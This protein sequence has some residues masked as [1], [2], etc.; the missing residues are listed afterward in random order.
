MGSASAALASSLDYE[1]T[2]TTVAQ[3]AVP[4]L[5]D[6][7]LV[8]VATEDGRLRRVAV[9]HVDPAKVSLA[10]EL[11][12]RY[13]EKTDLEAGVYH[14]FRTGKSEL[15]PEITEEL[16]RAAAHDEGHLSLLRQLG[17]TSYLCVPLR[18]TGKTVGVITL[19]SASPERRYTERDRALAEDL[20]AR[21]ALA[22]ENARLY[23]E[24]QQSAEWLSTTLRSIGDAVV[25]TDQTGAVKFLNPVAEHLTGW[26]LA[27]AAGQPL[28]EVFKIVNESTGAPVE[29]PVEKALATGRIV[30]LANHTEL[31]TRSGSRIAIDDSAAPIFDLQGQITGVVLVFRDVT[32]QRQTERD[33]AERARLATF[34]A[35]IHMALSEAESMDAMLKRCTDLTVEFLDAAFVRIW[36]LDSDANVLE[37]HA[38][39]GLY[40]HLNG[41]HGRIPVGSFKIG[42]IA[43]EKRPHLTNHVIGDPRVPN[44]EWAQKEKLVSFAG[45]PLMIDGSVIGV[46][47]MFARHELSNATL[48]VLQTVSQSVALGIQ[49]KQAELRLRE[50]GEWFSVTLGSI[51]DAVMTVDM[52]GCI[53][54]LNAVAEAL[55]GW[56]TA[57]ACGRSMREVLRLI[58]ESTREPAVNPIDRALDEGVVVGLA[59]H[60]T[61]IRR[62]GREM[63][64]EDSAAPIRDPHGKIIGAVMVFHDVSERRQKELELERS[65][66]RFRLMSEVVPQLLYATTADGTVEYLNEAWFT[67]TGLSPD[68]LSWPDIAH[69]EDKDRTFKVWKTALETGTLYETECRIRRRDGEYRWFVSRAVPLRDDAGQIVRW[70]GSCTDI[71]EQKLTEEAL[72]EEY[73]ITEYLQEVAKALATE[74][75]LSKVVQIITDAGTRITRAQFGAFF[76][77]LLDEKGASYMLYTLSGVPRAAFD[78]FP[79]PRATHLFGPTFRGEGVI[80]AD[81]IRKDPRFG[82]NAPHYGMPAGHLPVVSYLA[83]P[84]ISRSGEVLGGL[85][86]GH[87]EAGVFTERDEKIIVGVAA[88]AAAAMDAARL[89]QREQ[90]ARALAEQASQAKDHFLATLSHELRTPLTPVLA[91]LSS[92]QQDSAL[93]GTIAEDLETVRRN[94]EL[95]ARLIDDLLDLT[96]ITRGKLE[97]HCHHVPIGRVIE[98]AIN[99]CLPDLKAK[100]LTL[101][102]ELRG[103][104]EIIFADSARITQILWNLLKNAIKFTPS[105]GTITVRSKVVRESE[106]EHVIVEVQDTGMGIDPSR[107]GSV[108]EAFEQGDRKITKQFGGLGLGLAISKAIAQSHSGTLAVASKGMGHGSTFTLTLPL[109]GCV[110]GDGKQ[111]TPARS[112]AEAVPTATI[113]EEASHR[114]LRILLVEDHA[115]TAAILSRVLRRMGHDVIHAGTVSAALHSA[116][117]E[118]QGEGID[119]VMSDLGLPDG[120]GLDLMRELSSK[121]SLR[122]IALSGFGMESDLEQSSAAGFSRHLIKPIDISVVRTTIAELMQTP[123]N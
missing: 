95:E 8:D 1:Q 46:I 80:R 113:N 110:D 30:G 66:E 91:I 15:V 10:R 40:T 26:P 117:A 92:L 52:N 65:E 93:P 100:N 112:P 114:S 120:S 47:G 59:N 123:N 39:S 49:R 53:T 70:Y 12:Q 25:V 4:K 75:D 89:Y 119:L 6:W 67:Y 3:L 34:S 87:A 45:Y 108:F 72:R 71:H 14:T 76:Y 50:H 103:T 85:F 90:Q 36:L 96:R 106:S 11:E 63:P 69:P 42:M 82:K 56:S 105:R 31:I 77:N 7:C 28:R 32:Q 116:H 109:H 18:A 115:D 20:A 60:T 9:A 111:D 24:S 21:S 94:V 121:Y 29:N 88:Q 16:L 48:N 38:S 22:I 58:N 99:T 104:G 73:I 118:M 68:A 83:V 37:L 41:A 13:P 2:L 54:F 84:V 98:D 19:I 62:D 97:L 74:L 57:D 107:L 43:Q 64:I 33:R 44:Q 122:G 61:L 86:F 79:M 5:A 23:R 78:K 17:L 55:T 102:R 51:G 101:V 27:E 81:D 35:E